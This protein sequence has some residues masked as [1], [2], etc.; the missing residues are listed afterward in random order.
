MSLIDRIA[1]GNLILTWSMS[2]LVDSWLGVRVRTTQSGSL[3]RPKGACTCMC[4]SV[5]PRTVSNVDCFL[6]L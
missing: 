3:N 2:D 5:A 6:R 1:M 4:V